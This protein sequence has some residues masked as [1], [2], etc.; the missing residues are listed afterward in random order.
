M[1]KLLGIAI[2]FGTAVLWGW[3]FVIVKDAVE[4][5]GVVS[6]LALRFSLGALV[7]LPLALPYLDRR[8]LLWGL[9]PGVIVGISYLLQTWGLQTIS[10]SRSGLIT[11]LFVLFAPLCNRL[12]FGIR[13][14]KLVWAA[15]PTGLFGLW[16]LLGGNWDPPEFGEWLTVGCAF[17]FGL[18]VAVLERTSPRLHPVALAFVQLMTVAALSTLA[19]PLV[20]PMVLPPPSVVGALLICGVLASAVCFFGQTFGQKYLPAVQAAFLLSLEPVFATVFGVMLHDDHLRSIQWFGAAV[21]LLAVF[22]VILIPHPETST[23]P[24]ERDIPGEWHDD[25]SHVAASTEQQ[26]EKERPAEKAGEDADR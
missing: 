22:T 15:M 26:P 14:A 7:L 16:C 13:N 4:D 10:A 9:A 21:M 1:K 3:T 18:H 25:A 5:Y 23:D 11:G 20:D 24:T 19:W 12:F 8:T 6:F 17:G 2:L